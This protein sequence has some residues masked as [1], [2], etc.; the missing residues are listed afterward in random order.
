MKKEINLKWAKP[1][2][3]SYFNFGDDVNP[4]IVEKLSGRKVNYI[5]FANSRINILK[6]F[7]RGLTKGLFTWQ[8][9]LDFFT[10]IT[11]PYYV[12]AAGSIIQWYSSQRALVWG[13]GI[14]SRNVAIKKANFLA[15]RGQ[16][17]RN[18]LTELGLD[19]PNVLGDPA[20]LLPI[21]YK[22]LTQKTHKLG[23]VPH[24]DHYKS[25]EEQTKGTGILVI[26]L[27]N[28]DPEEVIEQI[29]S[30]EYTIS[31]S[32]HGLIVSHAYRIKSLWFVYEEK[33]LAGDNVKFWDYFSSV[34]IPAYE[35]FKLDV[36]EVTK[37]PEYWIAF[38]KQNNIKNSINADLSLIQ[39]KLIEVAPFP[40]LASY[41]RQ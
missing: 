10:S 20:L 14:L 13:S 37:D 4:Y 26:N 27:N 41:K 23:I 6:Q 7:L 29:N 24:I 32:L 35:P 31:T 2:K 28:S 5:Y 17:T 18:R 40:V 15:V 22:P 3:S 21:I 16:Y 36:K 12:L 39:K 38:I 33:A 25:I 8:Y 1:D 11:A 19:A 9:L 30:C 34:D